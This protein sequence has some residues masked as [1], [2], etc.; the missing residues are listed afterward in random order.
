MRVKELIQNV[1]NLPEQ[2]K[3]ILIEYA[4]PIYDESLFKKPVL[5]HFNRFIGKKNI[6]ELLEIENSNQVHC[7][8][9]DDAIIYQKFPML[10]VN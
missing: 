3:E 8:C 9:F 5:A 10:S 2:P 6:R 1:E 4:C 7:Q